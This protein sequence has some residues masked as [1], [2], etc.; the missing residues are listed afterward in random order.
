M[1]IY[2]ALIRPVVIYGSQTLTVG[3]HGENVLRPF[4]RKVYGKYLARYLKRN[5]GGDTK[6]LKYISCVTKQASVVV[7]S[8]GDSVRFGTWHDKDAH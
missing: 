1:Q 2:T 7:Y 4:G 8:D 6:T 3:E 5:F